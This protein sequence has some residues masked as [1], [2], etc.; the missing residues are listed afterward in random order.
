ML[1]SASQRLKNT[2][3]VWFFLTA[4]RPVMLCLDGMTSLGAVQ[5]ITDSLKLTV[6]DCTGYHTVCQA[7]TRTHTHTHTD[8]AL[9]NVER[10]SVGIKIGQ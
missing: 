7:R 5:F 8:A 3:T 10:T 4:H 2:I 1:K 9:G 6:Q